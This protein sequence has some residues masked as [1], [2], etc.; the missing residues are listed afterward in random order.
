MNMM[1]GLIMVLSIIN[2]FRTKLTYCSHKLSIDYL[3]RDWDN[4]GGD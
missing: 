1:K 3:N 4:S 2:I